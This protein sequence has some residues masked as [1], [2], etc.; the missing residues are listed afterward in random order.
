MLALFLIVVLGVML[1]TYRLVD[2]SIWLDEWP[3]VANLNAA[4]AMT[5]VG[6][7]EIMYPEQAHAPLY[8]LLQY[9]WARWVGSSVPMLRL[10]PVILGMSA[11]P[12]IYVLGK[13]LYGSAV[14]L[15]A[16][17]CL[18]L[19]PQHIWH[20]QEIRTYE[21]VTPIAIVSIYAMFR[22]LRD[23]NWKW[24]CLNALA[25]TLLVWTH[26]FAVLLIPVEGFFFSPFFRECAG[27]P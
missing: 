8:Y 27:W 18:A 3:S 24:W 25:N 20:A 11:V 6:L 10:L 13:Y 2:Q 4:D 23:R 21:L 26:I 22:A 17:L 12:L 16:A 14:G 5:Y 7:I 1:R 15:V 9:Y 19:S